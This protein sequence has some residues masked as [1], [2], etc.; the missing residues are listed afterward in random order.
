MHLDS[1]AQHTII[2]ARLQSQWNWTG[3]SIGL[4]MA[5]GQMKTAPMATVT[6]D[7]MNH[8]CTC[9]AAVTPDI[10]DDVLLGY[11]LPI[12]KPIMRAILYKKR[13]ESKTVQAVTTRQQAKIAA[14]TELL[15]PLAHH[16]LISTPLEKTPP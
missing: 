5:L 7:I 16:P 8:T 14:E 2:N 1:A 9:T 6:L 13:E 12:F 4:R 11:D 15:Q 10:D 3:Q